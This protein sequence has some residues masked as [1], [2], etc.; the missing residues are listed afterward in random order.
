MTKR[1]LVVSDLKEILVEL[2]QKRNYLPIITS[3]ELSR[4]YLDTVALLQV[5][6]NRY[7]VEL[8][9]PSFSS[10]ELEAIFHNLFNSLL[11]V[12]GDQATHFRAYILKTV[13]AMAGIDSVIS[14]LKFS[15]KLKELKWVGFFELSAVKKIASESSFGPI[16]VHLAPQDQKKV[17]SSKG[18]LAGVQS[19]FGSDR[20]KLQ[21]IK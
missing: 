5:C 12:S 13:E 15:K 4:T 18:M 20:K 21:K 7:V 8:A 11:C 17:S 14:F 10:P 16:F 6:L 9:N 2:L 1:E 19:V 3:K